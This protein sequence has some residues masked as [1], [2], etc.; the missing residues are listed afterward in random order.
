MNDLNIYYNYAKY[1][2]IEKYFSEITSKFKTKL[3]TLSIKQNKNDKVLN[4]MDNYNINLFFLVELIREKILN[5]L[6]LKK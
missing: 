1:F 4:L 5:K 6:T 3:W 2:F